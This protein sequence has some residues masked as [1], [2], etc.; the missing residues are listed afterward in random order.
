MTAKP[1]RVFAARYNG[2]CEFC[3][4][5]IVQGQRVMAAWY[6]DGTRDIIHSRCFGRWRAK[7]PPPPDE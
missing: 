7:N 4:Q 2:W 1:S 3:G 5:R 6:Q